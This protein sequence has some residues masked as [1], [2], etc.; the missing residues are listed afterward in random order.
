MTDR[1]GGSG[2]AGT[3]DGRRYGS[4]KGPGCGGVGVEEGG[5]EG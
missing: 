3:R 4:W 2:P 5:R 1:A